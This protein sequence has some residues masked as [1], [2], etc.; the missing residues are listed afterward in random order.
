MVFYRVGNVKGRV[1]AI[2]RKNAKNAT[3]MAFVTSGINGANVVRKVIFVYHVLYAKVVVFI[4]QM[5]ERLSDLKMPMLRGLRLNVGKECLANVD[6][7][8]SSRWCGVH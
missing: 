8:D 2:R 1:L 5:N 4:G 3:A 7:L 6:D